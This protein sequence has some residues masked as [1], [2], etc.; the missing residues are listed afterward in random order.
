[1]MIIH[2]VLTVAVVAIVVAGVIVDVRDV[3][4]RVVEGIKKTLITL[5]II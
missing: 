3:A 1:L 4:V 2:Q 5:N